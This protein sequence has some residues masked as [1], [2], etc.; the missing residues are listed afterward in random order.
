[1]EVWEE[2]LAKYDESNLEE[3]L[4]GR[5][6]KCE[7][8]AYSDIYCRHPCLRRIDHKHVRFAVPWFKS[9]I[10]DEKPACKEFEPSKWQRWDYKYWRGWKDYFERYK[11]LEFGYYKG[12]NA[13]ERVEKALTWFCINGDTDVEYGVRYLDWVNGTM[14]DGNKLKAI[15]KHYYKKDKIDLGIQLYKLVTEDIDGVVVTDKTF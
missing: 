3:D 12:D 11:K 4:D 2:N 6:Y 14:F 1:M 9:Y 15:K 10:G 13:E 7:N 8:C 5:H